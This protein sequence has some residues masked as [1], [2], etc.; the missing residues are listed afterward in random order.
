MKGTIVASRYAKSL[1]ELSVEKNKIDKINEDMVQLSEVCETSKDFTNLLKNPV[2]N[3]DKKASVFNKLFSGK[4]DELSLAFIQLI[5]KNRRENLLAQIADSFINQVKAHKHILDVELISATPLEASAKSKIIDKVKSKY[6]NYSIN[7]IEKIDPALI[8][9]FK[10]K[11]EDKQID[12]SVSS[13]LTNLK[14]IL[15]N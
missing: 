13:Q 5:T 6:S 3:A 10:I 11:V 9:G 8:G 4:M 2:V 12:A 7:L 14:N 1:L 15:L